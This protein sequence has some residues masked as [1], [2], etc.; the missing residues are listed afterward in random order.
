MPKG[1][2]PVSIQ[3]ARQRTAAHADE[4]FQRCVLCRR[5]NSRNCCLELK[6]EAG[7]GSVAGVGVGSIAGVCNAYQAVAVQESRPEEQCG[8]AVQA[9]RSMLRGA[10][11]ERCKP[12]NLVRAACLGFVLVHATAERVEPPQV[13][14]CLRELYY[15]LWGG[16]GRSCK[17][18]MPTCVVIQEARS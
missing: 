4:E 18:K 7:V 15:A 13:V 5:A 10:R 12:K 11:S 6:L 2:K 16:V 17:N 9:I 8:G 3:H 1:E 14:L